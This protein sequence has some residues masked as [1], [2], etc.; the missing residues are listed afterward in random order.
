MS[1]DQSPTVSDIEQ[2]SAI[3]DPVL[4][5]LQITQCYYE[6]A[7]V[8]EARLPGNSCWCT[9]A[10]WASKQAGQTIRKEDLARNFEHVLGTQQAAQEAA[11]ELSKALD[12]LG[13]KPG[14]GDILKFIW[15]V[16]DPQAAFQRSSEAVA[17]GNLKVFAEI[18]RAFAQF[19]AAILM[20]ARYSP[21]RIAGFCQ[22]LQPGEPPAGQRYLRQAFDHYYQAIF[23]QDPKVQAELVLLANLEIGYHEQTRLQPEIN[24]ALAAPII[25]PDLFTRNLIR[26]LRPDWNQLN[27]LVWLILRFFGR[28]TSLDAAVEHYLASARQEAQFIVTESLMT[29]E[30][31]EGKLLRLGLDLDTSYPSVLQH[32][33]NPDL[34]ALLAQIDPTPDSLE[35][36][37]AKYWG[38]LPDRMNFITEMFRSYQTTPSMTEPPFTPGQLS[39]LKAG[40]LPEGRL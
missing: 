4:R 31:P 37:G 33:L 23:V 39:A 20:D 38:D 36:S 22:S 26:T 16:L 6:L 7:R 34:I 5:N 14:S 9:F 24:E 2:I 27:D 13:A 25:P 19:N 11:G 30:L 29:I 3:S 32:L 40:H 17:R 15:K 21:E 18:G 1:A 35:G 28:L 8:V 10:T 12:R